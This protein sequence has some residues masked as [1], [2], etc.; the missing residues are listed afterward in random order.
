[1]NAWTAA[2]H[3]IF[4]PRRETATQGPKRVLLV[5]RTASERRAIAEE[6]R[7]AGYIVVAKDNCHDALRFCRESAVLHALVTETTL[8]HMWGVELARSAS[9]CH[10]H[11]VIVC[12][13]RGEPTPSMKQELATRGWQWTE[14]RG[15]F[16]GAVIQQLQTGL[17]TFVAS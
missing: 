7:N 10:S 3:L 6:L 17:T 16:Y 4:Q 9:Q 14:K 11:L 8:P 1:V 13:C 12:V 5:I 2:P 15:S